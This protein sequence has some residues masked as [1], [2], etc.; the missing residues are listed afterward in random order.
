MC[1]RDSFTAPL[2]PE[3]GG[4][5]RESSPLTE[6]TSDTGLA[7]EGF[8]SDGGLLS[9]GSSESEDAPAS[10]LHVRFRSSEFARVLF[11]LLTHLPGELRALAMEHLIALLHCSPSN[12]RMVVHGPGLISALHGAGEQ[13]RVEALGYELAISMGS[14][15]VC[16]QDICSL[17]DTASTL[18]RR[19]D[20]KAARLVHVLVQLGSRQEPHAYFNLDAAC[21]P[22]EAMPL[23]EVLAPKTGY[24]VCCWLRTSMIAGSGAPVWSLLDREG[25]PTLELVFAPTSS[26]EFGLCVVHQG[27]LEPLTGFELLPGDESW[28]LLVLTQVN[29]LLTLYANGRRAA[30]L[31]AVSFPHRTHSMQVGAAGRDS[32]WHGQLGAVDVISGCCDQAAAMH[33]FCRGPLIDSEEG[34]VVPV[35]ALSG[36][37]WFHRNLLRVDPASHTCTQHPSSRLAG[38]L[39]GVDCTPA[40]GPTVEAHC[41]RSFKSCLSEIG[42]AER[43]LRLLCHTREHSGMVRLIVGLV[44]AHR[45][46]MEAFAQLGALQALYG[47][48]GQGKAALDDEAVYQLLLLVTMDQAGL[49]QDP[50]RFCCPEALQL[51]AALLEHKHTNTQLRSLIG[52]TLVGKLVAHRPNRL[53]WYEHVGMPRTLRMLECVEL[54]LQAPMTRLVCSV[55][56]VPRVAQVALRSVFNFLSMRRDDPICAELAWGVKHQMGES[57]ALLEA[58]CEIGAMEQLVFSLLG[59]CIEKTKLAALEVAGLLL[60]HDTRATRG[61]K[62]QMGVDLLGFYLER[63]GGLTRDMS[64]CVLGLSQGEYRPTGGE[65]QPADSLQHPEALGVIVRLLKSCPDEALVTLVLKQLAALAQGPGMAHQMVH[66]GCVL[67]PSWLLLKKSLCGPAIAPHVRALVSSLLVHELQRSPSESCLSTFHQMP[68]EWQHMALAG[69]VDAMLAKPLLAASTAPNVIR[70]LVWMLCWVEHLPG[71]CPRLCKRVLQLINTVAGENC[72]EAV[73]LMKDYKLL[74]RRDSI[75]MHVL[76]SVAHGQAGSEEWC[77]V[78]CEFC[79][80]VAHT[81]RF[82]QTGVLCVLALFQQAEDHALQLLYGML[83]K[84][85]VSAVQPNRSALS[86][87]VQDEHVLSSLWLGS[88]TEGLQVWLT[89]AQAREVV[90]QGSSMETVVLLEHFLGWYHS[91][92]LQ[93]RTDSLS[94]HIAAVL[95]PAPVSYTH[96]TLPTKRIV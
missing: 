63:G 26:L 84:G 80:L 60:H 81:P 19:S 38:L 17:L 13:P 85:V 55:M 47:A 5:Y 42:G 91:P 45:G 58:A 75:I 51:T 31:S 69:T 94:L 71:W 9:V 72:A 36:G 62:Q 59:S 87:L 77:D 16:P 20:P 53:F 96:L 24:S 56:S 25:R 4:S 7:S 93:E 64:R 88:E 68:P 49:V 21:A 70:N 78:I 61:F 11:G 39:T 10:M 76:H 14:Y 34:A 89:L 82:A 23:N 95:E 92:A 2:H 18:Q 33:T 28:T 74:H 12:Q 8:S 6:G 3:H 50:D 29:S 32:H 43:V 65:A 44:S 73:E 67:D 46:N 54:E 15:D 30:Q 41:T 27:R 57:G 35:E 86:A 66:Q 40:V 37:L 1:I 52:R 48:L 83:L 79:E 90:E 22:P